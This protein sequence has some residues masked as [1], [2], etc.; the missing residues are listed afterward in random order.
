M[1]RGWL[2]TDLRMNEDIFLPD[3]FFEEPKEAR[4]RM[5]YSRYIGETETGL[6]IEIQY[7]KG[8]CS[9]EPLSSW[10]VTRFIDFAA[11]WCG[12][13]VLKR[14]DHTTVRVERKAK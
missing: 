3:K 7:E 5:I 11:I 2:K 14:A 4:R 13:V 8:F 10:R 6:M 9:Q 1:S 12:D